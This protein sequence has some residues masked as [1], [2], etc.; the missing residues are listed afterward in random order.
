MIIEIISVG[1]ELLLGDILN[2]NTQFLSRE[3]ATAGYDILHTSVVGDNAKRLY[4]AIDS[5]MKRCDILILTGGLGSTSDDI[6]KRIVIDYMDREVFEDEAS[7]EVVATWFNGPNDL[8]RNKSSYSFPI[9][10]EVLKNNF[11]IVSGAYIPLTDN[12]EKAIVLLPG[13]PKELQP[14]FKNELLPILNNKVYGEI[15]S[16]EVKIGILGEYAS[17][18]KL[19][20][21]IDHSTNPTYAP[22]AKDNGCIIRITAKAASDEEAKKM[23]A[24]EVELTKEVLGKY[25]VSAGPES[26]EET[27]INELRDKELKIATAESLTGGLVSST[28]I[29]VPGASDVMGYGYTVYS[30]EAKVKTLG[31]DQELLDEYTAVS[32]EVAEDMALKLHELTGAD[33]CIATTGYAGPDGDDVGQ[34]YIGLYN[35]GECKVVSYHL[36]GDRE[37]IRRRAASLAIDNAIL[38]LRKEELDD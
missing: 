37:R 28:L 33:F 8:E 17:Y 1:T 11:G 29:S 26:K 36:S 14:M 30:D 13:P 4:E 31:V 5:A 9:G 38:M 7:K 35:D 32:K 27:F 20:D 15:K 34:V 25:F 10:S 16:V 19:Q 24:K 12:E 6:T 21:K 3:L 23:L 2:T 22:Y 18:R